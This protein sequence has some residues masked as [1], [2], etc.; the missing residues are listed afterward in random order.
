[1]RREIQTWNQSQIGRSLQQRN[2]Q[3]LF[4]PP[5]G[6]HFGG[7]WERMIRSIRRVM[8]S[9]LRDQTA[10]LD[11]E[12]LQTVMCEVEQIL[13]NRPLTPSSNDPHDIT[14]L[15]PNH[16][17]TACLLDYLQQT[18][19][20]FDASGAKYNMSQTRSGRDGPKNIFRFFNK[21]R[22]GL[23]LY[24]ISQSEIL[25]SSLTTHLET[26]GAWDGTW[27]FIA[28]KKDLFEW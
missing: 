24:A 10:T 14:A 2:I 25:S 16:L 6:F 5:S 22:N 1:M 18:T 21:D 3:W 11:D 15:T 7:F 17:L 8:Y 19:I 28:I 23:N 26:Y 4:N 9:L 13:N 20:M 12:L 27:I